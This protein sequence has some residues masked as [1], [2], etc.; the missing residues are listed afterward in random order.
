MITARAVDDLGAN[1]SRGPRA[2]RGTRLENAAR[3]RSQ[4]RVASAAA[5]SAS[6]PRARRRTR[7]RPRPSVSVTFPGSRPRARARCAAS[8]PPDAERAER[9]APDD[10]ARSAHDDHDTEPHH[11]R[12]RRQ[13]VDGRVVSSTSASWSPGSIL[14]GRRAETA[15][16]RLAPGA[17]DEP[18]RAAREPACRCRRPARAAPFGGRPRTSRPEP[19]PR[20]RRPRPR[21]VPGFVTRIVVAAG[22]GE[23]ERAGVARQRDGR[24]RRARARRSGHERKQRPA[25]GSAVR[26]IGRSP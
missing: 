19:G 17:S 8:A 22:A 14:P 18:C 1:A 23:G 20:R 13:T 15:S 26:I 24:A 3:P 2:G 21:S 10:G 6:F 4:V 25:R 12:R 7:T 5:C 9:E 11:A 16:G